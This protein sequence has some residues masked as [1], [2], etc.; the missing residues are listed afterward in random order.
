M[1]GIYIAEVL[2]ETGVCIVYRDVEIVRYVLPWKPRKIAIESRH[3]ANPRKE[4]ID[5]TRTKSVEGQM[6]DGDGMHRCS[7]DS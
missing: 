5:P 2:V 4:K 3:Q 1:S 7:G 6:S